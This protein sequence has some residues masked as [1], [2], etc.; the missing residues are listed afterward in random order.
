MNRQGASSSRW[1]QSRRSSFARRDSNL[2]LLGALISGVVI[3]FAL[4]L[5]LMQQVN[6]DQG[7]RLRGAML[8]ALQPLISVATAPVEAGRRVGRLIGDHVGAV[9]TN[10]M[11]QTELSLARKEAALAEGLGSENR[12]MEA[13]LKLRRPE[14]RLVAS[15][16]AAA[17]SATA[18]SRS[19]IISVGN[20]DGVAPRMPV[21][22]AEGLAGR[23]TDVGSGSARIML[24][25]DANSRVPVKVLRTGWT[26]LAVGTG[27]AR[28]DFV[29]D[30]ASG[31]D[32]LREGDRLVTS[33]DGGLFPPGIPV[34]VL[35]DVTSSPPKARPLANPAGLGPVMVEAPWLP[36]PSFVPAPPAAPEPDLVPAAAGAAPP[37]SAAAP[38]TGTAAA[39]AP[40][41]QGAPAGGA[42]TPPAP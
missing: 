41:V 37:A 36:P 30:L 2:A 9:E 5:L 15:G 8:D 27:G 21:I 1:R 33:G 10:R 13:L 29:Y 6:P 40:A 11:L 24:I 16:M 38:P 14:R 32:R 17:S 12:R 22:A 18:A 20:A 28:L 7:S 42:A 39:Q 35:I 3:A 4:L 23:V 19:A 31:T 34:A 25:T 26:G